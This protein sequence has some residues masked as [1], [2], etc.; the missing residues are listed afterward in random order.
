MIDLLNN[1]G[2]TKYVGQLQELLC[3]ELNKKPLVQCKVSAQQ[4]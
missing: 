3:I 2:H 4:A 1:S